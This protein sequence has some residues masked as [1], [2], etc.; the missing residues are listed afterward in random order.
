VVS[1]L[2][3]NIG[4]QGAPLSHHPLVCALSF[5]ACSPEVDRSGIRIGG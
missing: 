4:I 1:R 3:S 5:I 2:G